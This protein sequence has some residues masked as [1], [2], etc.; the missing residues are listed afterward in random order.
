[1]MNR[2]NLDIVKIYMELGVQS[3]QFMFLPCTNKS[4][5]TCKENSKSRTDIELVKGRIRT[6]RTLYKIISRQG[7][8]RCRNK[9]SALE[10][11]SIC[12]KY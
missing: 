1:M 12:D 5:I 9:T 10:R 11:E 3:E 2:T 7:E 6:G 8:S 4:E